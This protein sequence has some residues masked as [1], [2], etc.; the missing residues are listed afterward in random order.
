[1]CPILEMSRFTGL[2]YPCL[3]LVRV[4]VRVERNIVVSSMLNE[5]FTSY[6]IGF[7]NVFQKMPKRKKMYI[8]SLDNFYLFAEVKS[9]LVLL[10][11]NK[12]GNVY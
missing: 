4:L 11:F 12:G 10:E 6:T 8:L 7:R 3:Y 2:L 5:A 9:K 1:M